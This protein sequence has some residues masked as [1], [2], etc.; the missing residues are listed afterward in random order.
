MIDF[1]TTK[2][3]TLPLVFL[4]MIVVFAATLLLAQTVSG[5][6]VPPPQ[7]FEALSTNHHHII[8]DSKYQRT[9][10]RLTWIAPVSDSYTI[11]G[12]EMDRRVY[13]DY[14]DGDY[15]W[16][17]GFARFGSSATSTNDADTIVCEG[18]YYTN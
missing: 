9:Y 5:Q 8:D 18:T 6:E 13:D 12:Y 16:E 7:K 11:T 17:V 3:A 10:I 14:Y 2:S 4:G 15:G 1:S